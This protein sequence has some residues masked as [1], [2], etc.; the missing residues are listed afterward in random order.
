MPRDWPE[1]YD[2]RSANRLSR[3]VWRCYNRNLYLGKVNISRVDVIKTQQQFSLTYQST[4]VDTLVD[5]TVCNIP[6]D[7]GTTTGYMSKQNINKSFR[8]PK[9]CSKAKARW[10]WSKC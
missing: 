2:R 1:L 6:P 3:H 10:K 7:T 8:L 5:G 9:G 4:T